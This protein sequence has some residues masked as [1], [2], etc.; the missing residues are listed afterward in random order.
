M[1]PVPVARP[2]PLA[3]LTPAIAVSLATLVLSFTISAA[4]VAANGG[5]TMPSAAI[6][7]KPP[8]ASPSLVAA[9]PS[10]AVAA[11]LVPSVAAPVVTPSPS[12]RE[13]I[14]CSHAVPVPDAH[15]VADTEADTQADCEADAEAEARTAM[16]C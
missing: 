12:A 16:R 11:T 10:S 4:F 2:R 8:A 13:R 3:T 14:A 7:S 9:A 5:L 6:A 1:T 15:P